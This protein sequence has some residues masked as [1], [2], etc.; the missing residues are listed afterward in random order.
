VDEGRVDPGVGGDVADAR[1]PVAQ[2]AEALASGRE[3]RVARAGVAG[4]AAAAL[5]CGRRFHFR[6][7]IVYAEFIKR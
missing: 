1:G 4:A 6:E 7:N 2:R 5:G 3:D